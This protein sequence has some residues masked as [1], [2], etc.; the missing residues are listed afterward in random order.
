MVELPGE[1]PRL[2]RLTNLRPSALRGAAE[3]EWLE[4]QR[5]TAAAAARGEP[6]V[7]AEVVVQGLANQVELNGQGGF[8]LCRRDCSDGSPGMVVAMHNGGARVLRIANLRP[9]GGAESMGTRWGE[10]GR[11]VA[12]DDDPDDATATTASAPHSARRRRSSGEIRQL[13]ADLVQQELRRK[14]ERQAAELAAQRVA[15]RVR[16]LMREEGDLRQAAEAA[17]D[18]EYQS[19]AAGLRGLRERAEW[20]RRREEAHRRQREQEEQHSLLR[21]LQQ[22]QQQQQPEQRRPEPEQAERERVGPL[23]ERLSQHATRPRSPA[24]PGSLSPSR[25]PGPHAG[26]TSPPVGVPPARPGSI[27][28]RPAHGASASPAARDADLE[29]LTDQRKEECEAI[30]LS[31]EWLRQCLDEL[32]RQRRV[33]EERE[34]PLEQMHEEINAYQAAG[35][36]QLEEQRRRA[37]AAKYA[38]E[39]VART[40]AGRRAAW[41]DGSDSSTQCALCGVRYTF[42]RRRHHCRVCFLSVCAACS[43]CRNRRGD[44]RCDHCAASGLLSASGMSPWLLRV[45]D[46][47]HAHLAVAGMLRRAEARLRDA[48]LFGALGDAQ[49]SGISNASLHSPQEEGRSRAVSIPGFARQP[50]AAGT[51]QGMRQASL[52]DELK[53]RPEEPLHTPSRGGPRGRDAG[54]SILDR[55]VDEVCRRSRSGT[56]PRRLGGSYGSRPATPSGR[57]LWHDARSE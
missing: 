24:R 8:A 48:G 31:C 32:E 42:T 50:S 47:E 29:Q 9:A 39:A 3:Q 40:A 19:L 37:A 20:Q 30:Q 16:Q 43:R 44:R 53:Y 15:E 38:G 41:E 57:G 45:K 13:V 25:S 56:P 36:R 28:P 14:D 7:G 26:A 35:Q 34:G 18:A 27:S 55:R 21:R 10:D 12:H 5:D 6:Y 46:D 49:P 4:T 17:E 52:S 11:L 33:D 22:Q 23:D 54:R 51:P 2:L 1:Q